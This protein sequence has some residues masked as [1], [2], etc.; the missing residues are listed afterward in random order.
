MLKIDHKWQ[1]HKGHFDD[2]T[3]YYIYPKNGEPYKDDIICCVNEA[4]ARMAAL[5]PDMYYLLHQIAYETPDGFP[6]QL[7]ARKLL[8]SLGTMEIFEASPEEDRKECKL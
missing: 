6:Y 3:K 1:I 5:A 8:A 2:I 4:D 7:E